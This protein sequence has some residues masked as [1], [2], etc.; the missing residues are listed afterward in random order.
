MAKDYYKILGVPRNASDEEIKK[1]YR[2]LAMKYHPDRN[3]D[4][5]EWANEK[6]KEINEAFGVLGDPDKRNRYDRFGT[7]GDANDIF[8]S[9]FTRT[10]FEDMMRDFDG[11]GLGFGFLNNIF[12]DLFGNRGMPFSFSDFGRSS[13]RRSRTRRKAANI[14]DMFGQT[15]RHEGS[16][17]SDAHYELAI[18][19]IEAKNGTKKM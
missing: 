10:T 15:L 1:S 16:C 2:K 3:P 4:K 17:R 7:V 9:P 6:F 19:Q 14:N 8:N 18:S 5:E 12:G 11:A 13:G